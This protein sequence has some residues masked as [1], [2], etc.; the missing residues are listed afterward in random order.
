MKIR[1]IESL[2]VHVQEMNDRIRGRAY[3][4]FVQRGGAPGREVDDW[5]AACA[6]CI[7][8]P[9]ITLSETESN[10]VVLFY[11]PE[12]DLDD[13]EILATDRGL[14]LQSGSRSEFEV[15][16]VIHVR[17]FYPRQVFRA[18]EFP[19]AIDPGSIGVKQQGDVIRL[20]AAFAALKAVKPPTKT[21]P[22]TKSSAGVK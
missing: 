5:C 18:V 1:K 9:P 11:L 15:P 16:G 17:E 10:F 7:T 2:N 21:K 8:Q 13:L 6:E 22:R 19:R 14:L 20:T 4:R 3:E 12:A